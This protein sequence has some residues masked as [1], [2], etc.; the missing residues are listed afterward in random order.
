M[1]RGGGRSFLRRNGSIA[2]GRFNVGE[3]D[4][5]AL[6]AFVSLSKDEPGCLPAD[7]GNEKK[8]EE[9]SKLFS[10]HEARDKRR[11]TG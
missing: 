5:S 1:E 8:P 7:A 3:L 10:S 9:A 2:D 11:A 4:V 6:L